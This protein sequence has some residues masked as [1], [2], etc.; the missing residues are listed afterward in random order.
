MTSGSRK[1]STPCRSCARGAMP[2]PNSVRWSSMRFADSLLR[3]AAAALLVTSAS[4][5]AVLSG[6]DKPAAP[7]PARS[8]GPATAKAPA[9]V[10]AQNTASSPAGADAKAEASAPVEPEVPLSAAV[11]RDFEA[12]RSALIGGRLDEAEHG[13]LALTKSNPEL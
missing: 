11:Q 12:A 4:G 1:V 8:A 7:E 5:C 9:A 6:P 13:F 3:A 10:A 2:R